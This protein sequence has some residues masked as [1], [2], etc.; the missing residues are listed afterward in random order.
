MQRSEGELNAEGKFVVSY[1]GTM[2][3]AH[4]LET[5]TL[6]RLPVA[7]CKSRNCLSNAG[8]RCRER[9]YRRPGAAT[10]A[11]PICDSSISNPAKQFPPTSRRRT[12]VL[13][14][15]RKP[16][17]SRQSFPLK[18]WNSCHAL[19][20]PVIAGR[21]WASAARFWRNARGG[22]VIEPENLKTTLVN[23][24]RSAGGRIN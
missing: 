4:G 12:H 7:G 17:C 19:A 23:A 1:I 20:A 13:S 14:C 18:C 8:R 16:N 9:K 15:S 2:G 21:R 10:R 24:I 3:M 6:R 11:S 5:I 22:L